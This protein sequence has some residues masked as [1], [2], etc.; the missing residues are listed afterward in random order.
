MVEISAC[1]SW[2]S[3]GLWVQIFGYVDLERR[4]I[5]KNEMWRLKGKTEGL[6]WVCVWFWV[7]SGFLVELGL[8]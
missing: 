4:L 6:S 1:S 7:G 5:H 8:G 3:V 2:R